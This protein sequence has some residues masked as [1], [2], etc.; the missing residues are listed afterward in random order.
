MGWLSDAFDEI[1]SFIQSV[2]D[3]VI[4]E[5]NSFWSWIGDNIGWVIVIASVLLF[6]FGGPIFLY[7]GATTLFATSLISVAIAVGCAWLLFPE[8]TEAKAI[9]AFE[10]AVQIASD[11]IETVVDVV[12]DIAGA[13]FGALWQAIK[14]PVLIAGGAF[15]AYKLAT[16]KK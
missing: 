4:Q 9:Q 16:S 11:V 5:L 7:F 3:S 6:V 14:T 1:A 2:I 8:E 15:V 13:G 12:T 10:G